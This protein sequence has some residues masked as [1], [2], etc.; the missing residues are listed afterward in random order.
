MAT[1]KRLLRAAIG[2]G[3]LLAARVAI[4]KTRAYDLRGKTVLVTGGSRGLGLVIARQL[5]QENAKI[6]ICARDVDELE[7]AKQDLTGFG[8]EVF[9]VACDL[10]VQAE[11][12]EMVRQ[13][14]SQVGTI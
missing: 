14:R 6:V 8:G 5:V 13:V 11:V 1:N 10:T 9:T 7:R 4:R 12:E 3:V 2:V